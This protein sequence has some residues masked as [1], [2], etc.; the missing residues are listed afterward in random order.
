MENG[1]SKRKTPFVGSE[2]PEREFAELTDFLRETRG[3]NLEMYKDQCIKRRIATRVRA[4]GFDNAAAYLDLLR[5]Q[6]EEADT[7]LAALTIHVSQFFRNPSTF[8]LLEKKVLP[9]LLASPAAPGRRELRLWSVGCAGGE[10][11]YS[12]A[13]LLA[14]LLK[15]GM[16]ARILGTDVSEAVLER[17]R[18]G[19][20]DAQRLAEVPAALREQCFEPA[21]GQYRLREP[22]RRLVSFRHHNILADSACPKVDL[23][24]CRNVLIYFSREEQEK[25]L[26]RFADSLPPGGVLVLGKSETLLGKSRNCFEPESLSERIYRRKASLI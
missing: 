1:L 21:G 20:F 16:R 18:Q 6:P 5:R 15:E 24:M 9:D 8:V 4:R 23:I 12:L 10:E 26:L 2:F 11:P 14:G 3:F 25:I 22:F 19:I 17:A 13:I 7:L